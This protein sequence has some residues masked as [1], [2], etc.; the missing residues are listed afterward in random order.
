MTILPC[1]L[2]CQFFC[3]F[4]AVNGLDYIKEGNGLFYEEGNAGDLAHKL[5]TLADP[6]LRRELGDRGEKKMRAQF[7]WLE[8]ARRR[9]EDYE[10]ACGRG[11]V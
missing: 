10:A 8:I 9:A 1:H 2:I 5:L 11:K 4:F 6:A 3:E 7:S